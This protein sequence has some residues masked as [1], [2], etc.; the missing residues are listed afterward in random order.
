MSYVIGTFAPTKDGGWSGSVRT[1]TIDTKLR[2]VPNDNRDN[3]NAPAFRVYAGKSRVGDAWTAQTSGEAPKD[4]L[5]VTFDG[6][7]F[8]EPFGA[9]LFPA[10]EGTAAQLAWRRRGG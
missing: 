7:D 9:A 4:F 5:R 6:P 1:L 10:D 2:F 8:P 3:E